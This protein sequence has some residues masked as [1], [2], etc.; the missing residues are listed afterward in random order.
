ME[1]LYPII[2]RTR[3]PLGIANRQSPIADLE[4]EGEGT[5]PDTGCLMPE[6]GGQMPEVVAVPAGVEAKPGKRRKGGR[7]DAAA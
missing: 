4:A 7:G 3:R 2:R 1:G 6:A 5:T